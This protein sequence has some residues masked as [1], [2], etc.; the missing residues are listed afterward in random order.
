V[1][2]KVGATADYHIFELEKGQAIHYLQQGHSVKETAL[3]LGY[4]DQNYFST[5][6]KRI[7]GHA[8]SRF[9]K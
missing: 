7:T 2:G 4:R 5:A 6:F 8:P 1:E 3:I 9:H